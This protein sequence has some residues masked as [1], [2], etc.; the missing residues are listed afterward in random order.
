MNDSKSISKKQELT[1]A[2]HE[3]GHAIEHVIQ[4]LHFTKVTIL[5]NIDGLGHVEYNLPNPKNISES[6]KIEILKKLSI[7][8]VMGMIAE[9]IYTGK[10]NIQGSNADRIYIHGLYQQL[11]LSDKDSAILLA[12]ITAGQLQK[13]NAD[14][15]YKYILDKVAKALFKNKS[16]TYKE[17]KDIIKANSK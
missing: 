9:Y 6:K 7:I 13:Y 17:V 8:S 2:R 4:N 16:M 3:A 5:P 1:C 10:M 15:I 12:S 14:K 11:G